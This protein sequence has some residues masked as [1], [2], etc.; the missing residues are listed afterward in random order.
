[1]PAKSNN[2]GLFFL[3]WYNINIM[4]KIIL[5]SLFLLFATAV[6][7]NAQ[8]PVEIDFFYSSSCPHCNQEKEFLKNLEEKYPKIVIK[9]H[10]IG[11]PESVRLLRNLYLE[12]N[13]PK[14]KYGFV[15]ATFLKGHYFIGF[16]ESIGKKIEDCILDLQDSGCDDAAGSATSLDLDFDIPFLGEINIQKYSF[17]VLAVLLGLLDGFNICS[18]GALVLILGL[19][20]ALKSRKKTLLFGGLFILTTAFVYGVLII[21]WYSVFSLF[22]PY[23]NLMQ[24]LIGLLGIAGGAYFLAEFL[25]FKKYGPTCDISTGKKLMAG[26]SSKFQNLLKGSG[27]IILILG[28][29][30]LFAIIITIIE[31]PCSA[32][33]PVAFAGA[34]AQANLPAFY[35][36]FYIFLFILFYM[37]DE[38]IVFL[39]AFF[40]MKIWL[41][42]SKAVTWV[43][44]AE[45]IILFILGIYYLY[46][47]FIPYFS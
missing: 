4:K 38:I 1:L 21:A 12:H 6:F 33:V 44:L 34:L 17:P 23:M 15:P 37:L 7:V 35:Y 41:A 3:N 24:I 27:G 18:L 31:F 14:E 43:A 39:I 29:I 11:D 13:V 16:S 5:L 30:L 46:A 32:V 36:L 19:V 20:L 25:K 45:S 28:N 22:T 26:F 47:S 9:H 42:S 10:N 8:E 2:I 40:T